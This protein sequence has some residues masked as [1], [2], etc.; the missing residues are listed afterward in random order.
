[1]SPTPLQFNITLSIPGGSSPKY[2]S[3]LLTYLPLFNQH[4]GALSPSIQ[5]GEVQLQGPMSY[6]SVEVSKTQSATC[7][8]E[9]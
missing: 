2:V 5:F 3:K 1:M 6:I 8:H 4:I 7:M 9:G